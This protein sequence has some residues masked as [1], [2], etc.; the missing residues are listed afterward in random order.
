MQGF[1]FPFLPLSLLA[2]VLHKQALC[3]G[4]KNNLH[5]PHLS[6]SSLWLRTRPFTGPAPFAF[7][8]QGQDKAGLPYL[9]CLLLI[10]LRLPFHKQAL[11]PGCKNKRREATISVLLIPLA[12][13]PPFHGASALRFRRARAGQS[14]A[15]LIFPVPSCFFRLPFHKQALWGLCFALSFQKANILTSG[16][17]GSDGATASSSL[18]FLAHFSEGRCVL[19][20][21]GK[22]ERRNFFLSPHPSRLRL[23]KA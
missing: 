12:S 3:L 10:F 15:C 8:G 7:G 1:L 9:P 16:K 23:F 21:R 4:R 11:R 14:R 17:Q 20:K 13:H 5:G 22:I 18:P 19:P 6:R 2:P